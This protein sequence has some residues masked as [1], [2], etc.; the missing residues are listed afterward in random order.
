MYAALEA[1]DETASS[2]L[3]WGA[4][5][6]KTDANGNTALIYGI[7]SKCSTTINLVAKVTV[8]APP[9]DIQY[10]W[11]KD[12]ETGNVL[13]ASKSSSLLTSIDKGKTVKPAVIFKEGGCIEGAAVALIPGFSDVQ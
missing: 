10:T 12:A 6:E 11:L 7:R 5:P 2:L 13:A 1:S 3:S 8:T 9:G 4:D